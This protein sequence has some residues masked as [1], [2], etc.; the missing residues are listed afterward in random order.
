[1][2]TMN[3]AMGASAAVAAQRFDNA[4]FRIETV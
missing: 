4:E 2:I 3:P 1:M